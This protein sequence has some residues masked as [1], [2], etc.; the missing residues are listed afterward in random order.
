M[1]RDLLIRK[2]RDGIVIDHIPAGRALV[3]LRILGIT[4]RDG[5]RVALVM[6]VESNK[7]GVKDIVKIEGKSLTKEELNLVSL[8]APTATINIVRNYEVTSKFKV[9]IPDAIEGLIKCKNPRCITNQPREPVKS[10]FKVISKD[11]V[12][13]VCEYCGT[14]HGWEDVEA[15]LMRM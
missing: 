13:L 1:S 11:P 7:L 10:R 3:V 9:T 15:S 8:A 2:I 12:K 14:M 4:G 5:L 6:N